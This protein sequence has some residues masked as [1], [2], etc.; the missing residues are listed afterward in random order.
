MS[1]SCFLFCEISLENIRNNF[2]ADLRTKNNDIYF[3]YD[4]CKVSWGTLQSR[5]IGYSK[6]IFDLCALSHKDTKI[7]HKEGTCGKP[8]L[9]L[10]TF[11]LK[12]QMLIS[13]YFFRKIHEF[14]ILN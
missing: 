11:I 13:Y 7:Y 5:L 6:Q 9:K 4:C 1:I 10:K 8:I 2:L 14:D 12:L 3:Y